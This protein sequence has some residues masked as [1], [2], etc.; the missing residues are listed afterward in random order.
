MDEDIPVLG[1]RSLSEIREVD[2]SAP[3]GDL[4]DFMGAH[5]VGWVEE[6]IARP[7]LNVDVEVLE[8][9]VSSRIAI[10]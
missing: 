1:G 3:V 8:S 10:V 4:G 6:Q 9:K 2:V 5:V 7:Q